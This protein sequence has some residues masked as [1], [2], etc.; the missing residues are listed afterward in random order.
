MAQLILPA[1]RLFIIKIECDWASTHS[2]IQGQFILVQNNSHNEIPF[3]CNNFQNVGPNLELSPLRV[4]LDIFFF[5]RL[6]VRASLV[7]L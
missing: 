6:C 3:Y 1:S 2:Y 4:P 5:L 7:L